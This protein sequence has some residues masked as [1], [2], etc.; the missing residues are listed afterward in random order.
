MIMKDEKYFHFLEA[1]KKIARIRAFYLHLALY[2][3]VLGL[4]IW[5]LFIIE[6]TP[7]TN[8]ILAINYSTMFVWGFCVVLNGVFVFKGK[9]IFNKK[10][11][12]R[13]LKEFL[14]DDANRWE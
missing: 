8:T 12:E 10:W 14:D 11:E 4:I 7:Y 2:I 13:K 9:S 6:D 1:K 3:V 5:N